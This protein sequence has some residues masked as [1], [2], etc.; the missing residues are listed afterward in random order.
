MFR[1]LRI[2]LNNGQ[3]TG[4]LREIILRNCRLLISAALKINF[5]T[6]L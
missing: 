6:L 1:I 3:S 5:K 2:I 4:N